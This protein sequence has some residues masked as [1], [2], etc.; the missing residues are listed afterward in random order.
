MKMKSAVLLTILLAAGISYGD[1][2][3]VYPVVDEVARAQMQDIVQ[4]MD[5]PEDDLK[6]IVDY[7]VDE[8]G[9]PNSDDLRDVPIRDESWEII[10]DDARTN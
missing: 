5:I 2:D 6:Q 8:G 10:R 4:N 7:V 1:D 3:P 9:Q